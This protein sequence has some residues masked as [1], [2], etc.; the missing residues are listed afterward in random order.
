MLPPIPS[1]C[2]N[3]YKFLHIHP[4]LISEKVHCNCEYC[5]QTPFKI[6]CDNTCAQG[7]H[8]LGVCKGVFSQE[9]EQFAKDADVAKMAKSNIRI[10][11]SKGLPNMCGVHQLFAGVVFNSAGISRKFEISCERLQHPTKS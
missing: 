11:G 2:P 9:R 10:L 8:G 4:C 5:W 3:E 6:L 7:L 1:P